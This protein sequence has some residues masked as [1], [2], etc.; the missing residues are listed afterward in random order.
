[1]SMIRCEVFGHIWKISGPP[2]LR[3]SRLQDGDLIMETDLINQ[4]CD[5]HGHM[6]DD[7]GLCRRCEDYNEDFDEGLD[8]LDEDDDDGWI[9]KEWNGRRHGTEIEE[10]WLD[11]AKALILKHKIIHVEDAHKITV[12]LEQEAGY[13][14]FDEDVSR[15]VVVALRETE[16]ERQAMAVADVPEIPDETTGGRGLMMLRAIA[17]REKKKRAVCMIPDCGCNGTPHS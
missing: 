13:A 14:P 6:Y 16:A 9:F 2:G 8:D 5:E 11:R 1:M 3:V 17:L 4:V 12:I 7:D 15:T 10:K